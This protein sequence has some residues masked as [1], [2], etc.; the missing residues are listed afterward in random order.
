MEEIY[1]Q[2]LEEYTWDAIVQPTRR[3]IDTTCIMVQRKPQDDEIFDSD[4]SEF[5]TTKWPERHHFTII[6]EEDAMI[7]VTDHGE[8]SVKSVGQVMP[9]PATARQV[10]NAQY[11]VDGRSTNVD[12]CS[13]VNSITESNT[14]VVAEIV[15]SQKNDKSIPLLV[16]NALV[17]EFR[18]IQDA[19]HVGQQVHYPVWHYVIDGIDYDVSNYQEVILEAKDGMM[20][21]VEGVCYYPCDCKDGFYMCDIDTR[22]NLYQ[23]QGN[24]KAMTSEQIERIR[25]TKVRASEVP[26]K[27]ARY[28]EPCDVMVIPIPYVV[29]EFC[30]DPSTTMNRNDVEMWL[31]ANPR[32]CSVGEVYTILKEMIGKSFTKP[33][34]KLE[35][36]DHIGY[37][38]KNGKLICKVPPLV[39]PTPAQLI[40]YVQ[41][42]PASPRTMAR[43]LRDMGWIVHVL[44]VQRYLR[45]FYRTTYYSKYKI[46]APNSQYSFTPYKLYYPPKLMSLIRNKLPIMN[47][48]TA[49]LQVGRHAIHDAYN[50]LPIISIGGEPGDDDHR[51]F[52]RRYD[53]CVYCYTRVRGGT[54]NNDIQLKA[55]CPCRCNVSEVDD[56]I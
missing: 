39:I 46:K 31:K 30:S 1:S 18:G 36:C 54:P 52:L 4:F 8:D 3:F 9:L 55:N 37:E 50:G 21:D 6:E 25:K 51:N 20:Y 7:R 47:T 16:Q 23:V 13:I 5:M 29:H 17:S 15:V 49:T 33:R 2:M 56:E 44:W 27:M 24:P 40:A 41:L 34:T 53:E 42:S 19:M 12:T 38:W 32:G 43:R 14:V 28:Y 10:I 35:I 26:I 11:I 48:W 45:M 22:Q